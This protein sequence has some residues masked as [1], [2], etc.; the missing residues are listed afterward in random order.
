MKLINFNLLDILTGINE[1]VV[2]DGDMFETDSGSHAVYKDGALVW[3]TSGGYV[4]SIISVT[5]ENMS[6]V[7]NFMTKG[8][9]VKISFAEAIDFLAKGINVKIGDY[10]N[11]NTLDDLEDV[12]INHEYLRD[13]Y[14]MA[15]FVDDKELGVVEPV[16]ETVKVVDKVLDLETTVDLPFSDLPEPYVAP[17]ELAYQNELSQSGKKL[18]ESDAYAILHMYH[19]SKFSVIYLADRYG[20]STRMIY[21]VLDGTHWTNVHEQFHADYCL[22]KDDY[23]K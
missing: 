7:F 15:C 16:T 18:T 10:G 17:K 11:I 21:Y 12:L 6:E 9:D 5:D 2:V 13:M 8:N 23:L 22:V 20:V 4:S 14:E 3:L 1:K 19:F